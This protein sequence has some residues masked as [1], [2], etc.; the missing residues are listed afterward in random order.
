[1]SITKLKTNLL[2]L[3]IETEEEESLVGNASTRLEVLCDSVRQALAI[4]SKELRVSVDQLNYEVLQKGSSGVWGVGKMPYRVLVNLTDENYGKNTDMEETDS[5]LDQ[6]ESKS[7]KEASDVEISRDGKTLVRIYKTGV[8][9]TVKPHAGTGIP[10]DIHTTKDK[11]LKAGVQE[12]KENIVKEAVKNRKGEPIKIAEW[13]P[14]PDADSTISVEVA[15]DEMFAYVNISSPRYGGRHL[16]VDEIAK[17][18]K[19]FGVV[20]GCQMDAIEMALEN[21]KYG[22]QILVAK[23]S[24]PKDG[25]DGYIEYK[26]KIDKKVEYKEDSQGRV[27]FLS[28][29]M[30]ENVVQGQLLAKLMPPKA[31]IPGQSI[32]GKM[33]SAKNG[34]KKELKQG[35]WNYFI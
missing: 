27:D 13:T 33:T 29:G 2:A 35:Q 15:A 25:E 10:A 22:Q 30:I 3:E 14:Q 24:T 12:Y 9:L 16:T 26:V 20:F 8:Y 31:G 5:N 1:M 19:N 6:M 21:E 17:T 4:A 11:I 18:L 32:T 28:T 7:K 34:K 23:G